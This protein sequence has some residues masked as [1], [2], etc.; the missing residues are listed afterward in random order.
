MKILMGDGLVTSTGDLW[1]RQRRTIQP[2]FHR[3]KLGVFTRVM[4]DAA[5]EMVTRFDA[6]AAQDAT[7]DLAEEL[8]R[9]TLRIVGEALL[10]TDVR[11]DASAVS[12]AVTH[13]SQD[14]TLRMKSI[15]SVPLGVPTPRNQ[16][17]G[18]EVRVL[19][20]LIGRIIKERRASSVS[21]R[22]DLLTLLMRAKDAESGEAMSDR[23]LTDE[24]MTMF[25]AGHE[26]VSSGL[27]WTFYCLAKNPRVRRKLHA[28][29]DAVLSG[30]PPQ[31]DEL[32]SLSYTERVIK[33]S[34]RL[35]PPISHI[36]R[37]VTEADEIGGYSIPQG[38]LVV[39]SPY[40][41]HRHP[42]FWPN[43]EGFDPER[44]LPES[45]SKRPRYAYF[46]FGGGPRVCIG[47][48]FSILEMQ[49]VVAMVA[50]RYEV[51]LVPG[52]PVEREM[53]FTLRPKTGVWVSLRRRAPA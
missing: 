1:K 24:V 36:P 8:T 53:L 30:R 6:H 52:R 50:Q 26:T 9:A 41:T 22:V 28:E 44:F 23:Q 32:G 40:A 29:V 51:N 12:R 43:P 35:F 15:F 38:S 18:A 48:F 17:F 5:A 42:E 39:V 13:L 3:E 11:G 21:E 33:E 37:R 46:P 47:N 27:A 2:L 31:F 49:I 7:F 20:D 34:L 19:F 16:R 25:L 10:G 4:I 45:E 14:M